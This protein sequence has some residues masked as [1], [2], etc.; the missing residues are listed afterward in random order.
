MNRGVHSAVG[1]PDNR[2]VTGYRIWT[3]APK[4]SK[5]NIKTKKN[6]KAE[7][8]EGEEKKRS[9]LKRTCQIVRLEN[10]IDW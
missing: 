5:E 9:H 1:P 10:I 8:I 2:W 4:K 6:K 7:A 3:E